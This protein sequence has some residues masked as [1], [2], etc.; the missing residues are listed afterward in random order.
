MRQRFYCL[1]AKQIANRIAAYDLLCFCFVFFIFCE[2][3]FFC[4]LFNGADARDL[5]V[6]IFESSL[7]FKHLN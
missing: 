4:H 7:A 1:R 2:V 6:R 5:F 3:F